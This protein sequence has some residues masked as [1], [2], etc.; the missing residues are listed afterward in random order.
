MCLLKKVVSGNFDCTVTAFNNEIKVV[1]NY[2]IIADTQ[3]EF[4]IGNAINNP[5]SEKP[6][7]MFQILTSEGELESDSEYLRIQATRGGMN[8]FILNPDS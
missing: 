1:V 6:S 4:R 7:N 2:D 3:F 8:K 5:I